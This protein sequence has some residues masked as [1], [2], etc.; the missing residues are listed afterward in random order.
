VFSGNA[1]L[2]SVCGTQTMVAENVPESGSQ[3]LQGVSAP[4]DGFRR[5]LRH[6]S[7][8]LNTA[9]QA[10]KITAFREGIEAIRTHVGDLTI[11]REFE[12]SLPGQSEEN[13]I[14]FAG[15]PAPKGTPVVAFDEAGRIWTGS[16]EAS[17]GIT[18]E[19]RPV[20]N[21]FR[22]NRHC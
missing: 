22:A 4:S 16:L 3:W 1:D 5:L 13:V 17:L 18:P 19:G 9:S 15:K 20:F 6:L 11:T 10:E 2:P 12:A 7:Q 21:A 8:D 14:V